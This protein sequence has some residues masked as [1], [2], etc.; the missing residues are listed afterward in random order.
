MAKG[1]AFELK[2]NNSGDVK[3]ASDH[4]LEPFLVYLEESKI[5]ISGENNEF[6][7]SYMKKQ[8]AKLKIGCDKERANACL[9]PINELN[10]I[11][12]HVFLS[13]IFPGYER[14]YKE[15]GYKKT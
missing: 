7:I 14:I 13:H 11:E 5:D 9:S 1:F 12:S 15:W 6:S 10:Q 4:A 2:K 3:W 8:I